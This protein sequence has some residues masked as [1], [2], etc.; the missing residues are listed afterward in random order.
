MNTETSFV[1]LIFKQ[2]CCWLRMVS[3]TLTLML[4]ILTHHIRI[5]RNRF[6]DLVFVNLLCE[7]RKKKCRKIVLIGWLSMSL[8]LTKATMFHI[9]V[10]QAVKLVL[11]LLQILVVNLLSWLLFAPVLFT[12]KNYRKIFSSKIYTIGRYYLVRFVLS[13]DI[14][15]WMGGEV[16]E[17][18]NGDFGQFKRGERATII[19]WRFLYQG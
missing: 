3:L 18:G 15:L 16:N 12:Q 10:I 19:Y 13:K 6:W 11:D 9:Y 5:L 4:Q 1:N 7:R 14:S 2:I 8:L 17:R